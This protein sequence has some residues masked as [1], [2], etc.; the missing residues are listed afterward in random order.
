[1]QSR[2]DRRT[3]LKAGA[4][5]AAASVVPAWAQDK[6]KLRFAAVPQGGALTVQ[7][8]LAHLDVN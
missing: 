3:V 1:M 4:A 5:F 2:F 7:L 6:P 8:D